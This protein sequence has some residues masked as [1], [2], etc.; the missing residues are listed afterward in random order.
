MQKQAP[1]NASGKKAS[2]HDRLADACIGVGELPARVSKELFDNDA[3]ERDVIERVGGPR[4]RLFV[5][6]LYTPS[7]AHGDG[8]DDYLATFRL[9]DSE[10]PREL[11]HEGLKYVVEAYRA[12]Q[13]Q[14]EAFEQNVVAKFLSGGGAQRY[15]QKHA[16]D[17]LPEAKSKRARRK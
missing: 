17:R 1:G 16:A 14:R 15:R 4:E 11:L 3:F 6:S 10:M 9:T 7:N 12:Y 5:G 13:D 2:F 8:A